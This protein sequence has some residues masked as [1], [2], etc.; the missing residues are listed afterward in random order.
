[1]YWNGFGPAHHCLSGDLPDPWCGA[2]GVLTVTL[3]L[4]SHLVNDLA[5]TNCVH[6]EEISPASGGWV[7]LPGS[8]APCPNPYL[9][10][11][12][13]GYIPAIPA[14]AERFLHSHMT[15]H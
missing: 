2:D 8:Y 6:T 10:L 1:M 13:G 12:R 7:L 9:Y 11:R 15:I 4:N 3:D 14:Q 5:W